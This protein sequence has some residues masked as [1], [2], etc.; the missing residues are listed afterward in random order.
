M[1]DDNSSLYAR[2][3]GAPRTS[4]EIWGYWLFVLGLLAGVVGIVLFLPSSPASGL[5][6][7]SIA[8][9]GLGLALLV[10]GPVIRLPLRPL[11]TYTT[12]LG[13]A[14]AVLAVAWFVVVFPS[15]WSVR[16]GNAG[17]V[18]LYAVGIGVVGLG[19]VVI[20]L[21]TGATAAVDARVADLEASLATERAERERLETELDAERE[22]SEAELDAERE[23][24]EADLTAERERSDDELA[25]ER[26]RGEA[27]AATAAEERAALE[28]ELAS[29]RR[30]QAQFELYQD[31][32]D[33]WRWRLRHRNGNVVADGGQ[34]YTRKHNAQKGMQSV[35]ANALGA[36]VVDATNVSEAEGPLLPDLAERSDATFD[37]YEDAGDEWRWRLVHDNGNIIADSGEGYTR[38]RDA[39]RA[40][41]SVTRNVGPAG[42]LRIDPTSFEV[43]RDGAGE[44]RWRLIHENGNVLAD[45]G[46]GYT[47]RRDARRAVESV[48]DGVGDA[49]VED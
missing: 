49:S 17:V 30:S 12:Y 16:T 44:W 8:V 14:V 22:R 39:E 9:G 2:R 7:A 19:G 34:G 6:E 5:R 43:Y 40:V 1:A 10:A 46:E 29:L 27:A 11:A 23:R 28:A 20:P 42:Y 36:A 13:L 18:G 21:L 25:R 48:R 4:D 35:R 15:G 45:S 26:E 41:E 24:S 31:T 3:I 37:I 47:R 32:A 38:R 33:E